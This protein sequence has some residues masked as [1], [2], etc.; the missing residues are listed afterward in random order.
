M[1]SRIRNRLGEH[2][3]GAE[4]PRESG[5]APPARRGRPIAIIGPYPAFGGAI[6]GIS[7]HIQRVHQLL[8]SV[9]HEVRIYQVGGQGCPEMGVYPLRH[10]TSS[11]LTMMTRER[12]SVVH[13][14]LIRS[15]IRILEG[16]GNRL[17]KGPMVLTV[18]G[19]SLRDQLA[20]RR[21]LLGR[22]LRRAIHNHDHLIGVSTQVAETILSAGV[23]PDR[24]SVLPAFVPPQPNQADRDELPEEVW[25]FAETHSPAIAF[26]GTVCV[27]QGQ[28]LY[29]FDLALDVLGG[30]RRS[31]RNAGLIVSFVQPPTNCPQLWRRIQDRANAPDVKGHV[32]FIHPGCQFYPVLEVSDVLL[33]P[34]RADGWGV[35]VAEAI[36]LGTPA[37]ASD[38]CDR[39]SGAYLFRSGDASDLARQTENALANGVP[40]GSG[41]EL[42]YHQ[43][44]LTLYQTMALR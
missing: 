41:A 21:G 26:N 15:H 44:L 7:V 40:Y 18:H 5:S 27:Y 19:N 14:H 2:D 20:R 24:V 36:Y 1:T 4:L 16:L 34:T 12:N 8:K 37:V 3:A 31:G 33:R 39:A 32:L 38:V 10:E 42:T 29:G 9:G 11:I 17:R 43:D 22:I 6:G 23:P 35:S 25:A 13:S 28:D 30:I